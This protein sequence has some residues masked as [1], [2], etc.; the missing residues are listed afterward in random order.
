MVLFQSLKDFLILLNEYEVEYLVIGGYAVAIHGYVRATG[1]ADI[2][3]NPTLENADKMLTVMLHFGFGEYDFKLEDFLATT[4]TG[5]ISFG[6]EPFKIELLTKTFGVTFP[7]AYLHRKIAEIDAI[8]VNFM[9]FDAL[10]A[11]KKALS[12]E[13]DL[14]DLAHLIDPKSINLT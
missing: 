2:W 8:N 7:E 9:G 12:R 1:D 13:K 4:E 10:I 14:N 3:I 5:F 11:N 6:D